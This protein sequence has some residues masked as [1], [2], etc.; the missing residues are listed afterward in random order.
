MPEPTNGDCNV[1][2]NI[3][4]PS[5]HSIRDKIGFY[6]ADS[7]RKGPHASL[8]GLTIQNWENMMEIMVR[9]NPFYREVHPVRTQ[10]FEST[11]CTWMDISYILVGK[12]ERQA[13]VLDCRLVELQT[14]QTH[15]R[16][17]RM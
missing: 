4:L 11:P 3:F 16:T 13:A 6:W 17:T 12:Q 2:E 7:D 5:T 10:L 15:F 8:T 9:L 14:L 1:S